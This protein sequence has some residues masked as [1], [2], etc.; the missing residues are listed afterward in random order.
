MDRRAVEKAK[1]DA[2]LKK[3]KEEAAAKAK[4]DEAERLAAKL[5]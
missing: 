1:L 2:E 5:A 3:A 4:G